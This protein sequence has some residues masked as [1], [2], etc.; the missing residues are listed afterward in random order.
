MR[1]LYNHEGILV[2]ML[3]YSSII[4][5]QAKYLFVVFIDDHFLLSQIFVFHFI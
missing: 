1:H 4:K 5:M 2:F 3:E